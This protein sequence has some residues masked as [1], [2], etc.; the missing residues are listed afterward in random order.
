[1]TAGRIITHLHELHCVSPLSLLTP[2]GLENLKDSTKS[3]TAEPGPGPGTHKMWPD[4]LFIP[5]YRAFTLI[6]PRA[7]LR[8]LSGRLVK[9]KK[10]GTSPSL[11]CPR[12]KSKVHQVRIFS[13]HPQELFS[14]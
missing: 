9:K 7:K 4:E 6:S 3:T 8:G 11:A 5:V 10:V 14:S 2:D 1:M 12:K 13:S